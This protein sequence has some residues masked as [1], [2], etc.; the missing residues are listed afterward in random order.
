MDFTTREAAA[1][2]IANYHD[3]IERRQLRIVEVRK[4]VR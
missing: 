4:R 1:D 2:A 3:P